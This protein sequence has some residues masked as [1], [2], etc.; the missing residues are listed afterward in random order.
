MTRDT[1]AQLNPSSHFLQNFL[2]F[3]IK[4]LIDC[5]IK[6][7]KPE[8]PGFCCLPSISTAFFQVYFLSQWHMY[9]PFPCTSCYY[10]FPILLDI[11]EVSWPF[12]SSVISCFFT[13]IILLDRLT[14]L[15]QKSFTFHSFK[16]R[17]WSQDQ[18][19]GFSDIFQDQKF[20]C[21]HMPSTANSSQF[22]V[23]SS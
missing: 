11:M 13:L 1:K 23:Q 17:V 22:W 15:R 10:L 21:N 9:W 18:T 3:C 12:F 8:N 6:T 19:S 14:C 20:F 16:K 2:A 7:P 4:S 5:L